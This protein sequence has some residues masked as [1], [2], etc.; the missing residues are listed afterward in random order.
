MNYFI[1]AFVLAIAAF[2]YYANTT[3]NNQLEEIDN[4]TLLIDSLKKESIGLNLVIKRQ[5]ETTQIM[6]DSYAK[7]HNKTKEEAKKYAQRIAELEQLNATDK[8][9][10]DWSDADIPAAANHWLQRLQESASSD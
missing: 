5:N 6:A 8:D 7:L 9:F 10:K 3:I 2:V 4:K 1:I